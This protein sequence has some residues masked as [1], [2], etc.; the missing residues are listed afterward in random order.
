MTRD[1]VIAGLRGFLADMLDIAPETIR[2]DSTLFADLDVD[3]LSVLEL[4][5]FSEDTYDVDL[6]PLL[7]ETHAAGE[8]AGVT[9]A[10]LADRIV[11]SAHAASAEPLSETAP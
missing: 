5:V 7:R 11:A 9:I 10:W 6:E 4:A 3:S 8:R 2:P 1:D